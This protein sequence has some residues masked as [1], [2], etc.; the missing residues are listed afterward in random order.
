MATQHRPE[1]AV[2]EIEEP[3]LRDD[4]ENRAT[5]GLYGNTRSAD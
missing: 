5:K 2:V 3:N 1:R 4:P